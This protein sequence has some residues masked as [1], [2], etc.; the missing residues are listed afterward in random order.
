[1]TFRVPVLAT[2]ID[3]IA[4]TITAENARLNAVHHLLTARLADGVAG[5]PQAGVPYDLIVANILARPLIGMAGGIGGLLA[6]DGA[7]I[8]SGLMRHQ[9]RAV[10]ARYRAE[11]LVLAR[12]VRHGEWSALLLVRP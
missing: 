5:A 1:M 3:P 4:V 11:G 2:D 8:L 12:A 6:V 10:L 9:E 7:L